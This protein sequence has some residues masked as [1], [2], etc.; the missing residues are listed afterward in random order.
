MT[1]EEIVSQQRNFYNTHQTKDISFRKKALLKMKKWIIENESLILQALY[2][3]LGKGSTESYMCE[4]GMVLSELNDQLHHI[5]KWSKRHYVRTPL[6]QFHS[7]SFEVAEPYGVVL[8][9][10]PWNY[11]FM[12]SLDPLIGAV[13][14]GNCVV[15][16][17]SKYAIHVSHVIKEMM[18]ELFDSQ[19][20]CVVEGGREENTQ[21]LEQ[22]FD[23]IFF[24]G[25]VNVGKVVMEKASHHLTP[26]TLEL[27][28]K[29]PCIVDKSADIKTAARRIAFGKYLNAGQTCV[30]VDYLLVH[31]SVKEQLLDE[32]KKT[33]HIFFGNQP[34]ESPELVKIIN[35]KHFNRLNHLLENQT[36]LEGGRSQMDLQRIEPTIVEVN[37][38]E[39]SLMKEEIFGPILP[40][41]TYKTIEEA[42]EMVHQFEK[43]LACYLFMNDRQ[44]EEKC[45]NEISFGGGCIN[46]T[47][48]HLASNKLGFGGVGY[49][50]M[51]QYHG[52]KS[53]DTFS[54]TRSV[55]KKF[56]WIDLPMRYYPFNK[57]KDKFIRMFMK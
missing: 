25:S 18:D 42:I 30:A 35:E 45:L 3:D 5:E 15:L 8:V 57:T 22:R 46:D 48:I 32:L 19:Y 28:G 47:I 6:A 12:L 36:I 44:I 17:P 10:S 55:V 11:P 37:S 16:K 39:N 23:Y 56:N 40:V 51:G 41:M 38:L 33:I 26:I 1:I 24:T 43:P 52:K 50:G 20:I 21:L 29:S 2:D 13:A 54:H 14:A 7:R 4:I 49:S 27:G 9:M 31:E 34:L 53:F